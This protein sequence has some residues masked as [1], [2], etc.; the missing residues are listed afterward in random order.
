V[1][2]AHEAIEALK[3]RMGGKSAIAERSAPAMSASGRN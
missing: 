1:Y 2:G 3:E